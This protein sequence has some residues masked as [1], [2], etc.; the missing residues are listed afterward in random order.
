MKTKTTGGRGRAIIA[1]VPDVVE[2]APGLRR[3]TAWHADWQEEVG[4]IAV[5]TDDGLALV[6]PLEPPPEFGR[7]AHVLLTVF[8]HIRGTAAAG[9]PHV[10]APRRAVRSL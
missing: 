6:D 7:P 10:W 1:R 9:A 5:E 3:W 8:W 4:C 2:V